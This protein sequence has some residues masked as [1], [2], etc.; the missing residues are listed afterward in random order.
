L[1]NRKLIWVKSLIK[2]WKPSLFGE[3]VK[4]LI[5]K[6]G[7]VSYRKR[8]KLF[9]SLMPL[10]NQRELSDIKGNNDS[11][12]IV[13]LKDK[14]KE[15]KKK[16]KESLFELSNYRLGI[17]Q[18]E[19]NLI[20]K[21][22]DD[23]ISNFEGGNKENK[24]LNLNNDENRLIKLFNKGS[25]KNWIRKW[26]E[27]SENERVKSLE[28]EWVESRES[29]RVESSENERVES[30]ESEW[31]MLSESG[32]QI[33][34]Q[35]I[36][37]EQLNKLKR[38]KIT[39][40]LEKPHYFFTSNYI[41]KAKLSQSRH[42][43]RNDYN[44]FKGNKRESNYLDTYTSK[45]INLYFTVKFLKRKR[46]TDS[47]NINKA[48]KL[49]LNRK[50]L[51][52]FLEMWD[53]SNRS[54]TGWTKKYKGYLP[55]I[56][57]KRWV[58]YQLNEAKLF[59]WKW[60]NRKI[61]YLLGFFAKKNTYYRKKRRIFLSKPIFKHR[62]YNLI[63][64]LYLF[65][66][67]LYK[68]KRLSYIALKRTLYKYMYSMYVDYKL[69]VEETINRPRF[70][71]I[72][73]IEPNTYKL[74]SNIIKQYRWIISRK[75]FSIYL[76][77]LLMQLKI[78]NRQNNTI[79]KNNIKINT[80]SEINKKKRLEKTSFLS[81]DN[82]PEVLISSLLTLDSSNGNELN[83]NEESK[84]LNLERFNLNNIKNKKRRVYILKYNKKI[85]KYYNR[86]VLNFPLTIV[87]NEESV[88][89]DADKKKIVEKIVFNI[90][91]KRRKKKYAQRK[92]YKEQ[93]FKKYFQEMERKSKTPL[94]E[95]T[96][97]MW[98]TNGLKSYRTPTGKVVFN[99]RK[100]NRKKFPFIISKYKKNKRHNYMN[101]EYD[102]RKYKKG[103]PKFFVNKLTKYNKYMNQNKKYIINDKKHIVNDKFIPNK[104]YQNNSWKYLG[105]GNVNFLTKEGNVDKYKN[106]INNNKIKELDVLEIKNI[107]IDK[108]EN[109]KIDTINV[110]IDNKSKKGMLNLY[111]SF[112]INNLNMENEII[113]L[114][115]I[116]K[117]KIMMTEIKKKRE[118]IEINDLLLSRLNES[119]RK[120]DTLI[121]SSKYSLLKKINSFMKMD[122][123]NKYNNSKELWNESD[124]S[125]AALFSKYINIG[126]NRNM[127]DERDEE[128][129][130]NF[131]FDKIRFFRRLHKF[132]YLMYYLS[133]V[134]REFSN[135]RRDVWLYKNEELLDYSSFRD[136]NT[137]MS[138]KREKLQWYNQVKYRVN[139]RI[140]KLNFWSSYYENKREKDIN[141]G[142]NLGYTESLF[143]P[144]YRYMIPH[145][146]IKSYN[147]LMHKI[148]CFNTLNNV[149][150]I[151]N[152]NENSSHYLSLS[153]FQYISVKILLDL[154][155]FNYR[156]MIRVKPK[157]Q[158]IN[159]L[160]LYKGKYLKLCMNTWLTVIRL[161][162]KLRKAPETFWQRFFKL[163]GFYVDRI[164]QNT[165]L[166]GNRRIFVP[167]VIYFED[168]LYNIYGKWVIVRIW[169][170][171][172]FFLSSYILVNR[173][174]LML[175]WRKKRKR[176]VLRF[177]NITKRIMRGNR[178]F[179]IH[180]SYNHYIENRIRWP[181]NLIQLMEIGKRKNEFNY[182]SLEYYKKRE[183]RDHI[184]N[185]YA[186]P[187]TDL[188]YVLPPVSYNYI[189]TT[190]N[191]IYSLP[192]FGNYIKKQD[193][194]ID[195]VGNKKDII[196]Y[197][198][199][200]F[201]QYL[202]WLTRLN[203]VSGIKFV[204]K[205]RSP[206]RAGKI[207]ALKEYQILGKLYGPSHKTVNLKKAQ[208]WHLPFIRGQY[209]SN[210]D[211]AL[212]IAPNKN[213]VISLRACLSSVISTDIRELLIYLVT[214]KEI[215]SQLINKYFI[216]D[217]ELIK[218]Y[219]EKRKI[220]KWKIKYRKIKKQ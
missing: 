142:L 138:F 98:K 12:T 210:L 167:F 3:L 178:F 122:V 74:Y 22:M 163:T 118:S 70:F 164:K 37:E 199:K 197:W 171:R 150:G 148:G 33:K 183:D 205:G 168:L 86:Y 56:L 36:L 78:F 162:K 159:K 177:K 182:S 27:F 136:N 139:N 151:L 65:N 9:S 206:R 103:Q 189:Q 39:Y 119:I 133:T 156:S 128:F 83:N 34:K 82:S 60:R 193:K 212:S 28:S 77:L 113:P 141:L 42:W 175:L 4:G 217:T 84:K 196:F 10:K 61:N 111:K 31:V 71:Y 216:V 62:S 85:N 209:R 100:V 158:F 153:V 14:N 25:K 192:L 16:D 145:L 213:G 50:F 165:E 90:D 13:N 112:Y 73:I 41:E 191:L 19:Y 20:K 116:K 32:R 185:T 121:Y 18:T 24:F 160:R 166:E 76:Y 66:S 89:Y 198:I 52:D 132:W 54:I 79:I 180:R 44:F 69:K 80:I 152:K 181:Q 17:K 96:L 172:K 23:N 170:L 59:T 30:S 125:F 53:F 179:E 35:W 49:I 188:S 173:L 154:L 51:V 137:Y 64:D 117:K 149:N 7:R 144:Y 204:I 202:T 124:N 29:E 186:T 157:Y 63:I 127:R 126:N 97:T 68:W 1:N 187:N 104:D 220:K 15:I 40:K 140:H 130:Y 6:E 38:R 26:V 211:Y 101:N 67:K 95:K 214:L 215:Y 161:I 21:K 46:I 208:S 169:P 47:G 147:I 131:V 195:L 143:K 155:R 107:E 58:I 115:N 134:N 55:N 106:I 11:L 75:P 43:T 48:Y 203:D 94:D 57:R 201:K 114:D 123:N 8:E 88:L 110:L 135:I 93:I 184:L 146:I 105:N 81:N 87:K 174:L 72:N 218:S 219:K 194:L 102:K 99:D 190:T 92:R 109:K 120:G 2:K 129:D 91:R 45:L 207:R 108:I 176:R 200:P 5:K